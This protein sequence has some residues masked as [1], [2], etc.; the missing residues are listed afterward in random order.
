MD[1]ATGSS[2][3][4]FFSCFNK[5]GNWELILKASVC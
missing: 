4:L 2:E 1:V 3:R 5:M